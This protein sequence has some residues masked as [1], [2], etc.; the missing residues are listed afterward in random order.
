MDRV[1]YL[2]VA[3]VAAIL[4]AGC[5]EHSRA[6]AEG[7]TLQLNYRSVRD[8]LAGDGEAFRFFAPTGWISS[9]PESAGTSASA[10]EASRPTCR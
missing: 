3:F 4:L 6:V 5:G 7:E 1:H 2:V 10:M 9:G 8:P